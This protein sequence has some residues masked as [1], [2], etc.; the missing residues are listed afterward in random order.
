MPCLPLTALQEPRLK[1]SHLLSLILKTTLSYLVHAEPA[2]PLHCQGHLCLLA[3]AVL[4]R[5]LQ[6][7]MLTLS[8]AFQSSSRRMGLGG[9]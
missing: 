2:M 5:V 7:A 8:H 9:I 4:G 3:P 1:V 6:L